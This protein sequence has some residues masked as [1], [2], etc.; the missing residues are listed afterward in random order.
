[1]IFVFNIIYSLFKGEKASDN[2]WESNTLEWQTSSPPPIENF[3]SEP[4]VTG[5][6]YGGYVDSKI[7]H[8]KFKKV[9]GGK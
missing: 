1:L 7:S 8:A 4:E 5:S 9:T 3:T 6:P 2:P